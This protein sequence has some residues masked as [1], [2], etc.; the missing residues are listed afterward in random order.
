[1]L[2]QLTTDASNRGSSA[3][4][5]D[6]VPPVFSIDQETKESSGVDESSG[7]RD[8]RFLSLHEWTRSA[9]LMTLG[10]GIT[11]LLSLLLLAI[12]HRQEARQGLC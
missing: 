12:W 10:V 2:N 3:K 9:V 8:E 1:V 4:A 5:G 6:T 11:L 7:S